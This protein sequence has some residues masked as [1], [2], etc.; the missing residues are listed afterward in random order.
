MGIL[1]K[2]KGLLP[3]SRV[4]YENSKITEI[5][6]SGITFEKLPK[7]FMAFPEV[8]KVTIESN[9]TTIPD[10]IQEM[11]DL[12]YLNI[13]LNNFSEIPKCL[14]NLENLKELVI[15]SNKPKS[16][17]PIE[18]NG[19]ENVSQI[20]KL[21]LDRTYL[22]KIPDSLKYLKDL[23]TLEMKNCGLRNIDNICSLVNLKEAYLNKNGIEK[24]PSCISQLKQLE[25]LEISIY[26]TQEAD[27]IFPNSF[28][29]LQKLKSLLFQRCYSKISQLPECLTNLNNLEIL[30]L[31]ETNFTLPDSISKL[32]KLKELIVTE[33]C[34][35]KKLPANIGWCE[36]LEKI[37]VRDTNIKDVSGSLT[38][39]QNL[40]YLDLSHNK[41]KRLPENLEKWKKLEYLDLTYNPIEYI[42]ES[43]GKLS[44]LKDL[45]IIDTPDGDFMIPKT[46]I[47]LKNL[48]STDL[49]RLRDSN[50]LWIREFVKTIISKQKE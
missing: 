36:N 9:L 50:E 1:V 2:I 40:R 42:P 37:T 45:Y 25:N 13:S 21:K 32:S 19:F 38:N 12:Q 26:N 33:N 7:I 3:K 11:S 48:E 14:R 30:H 20:T 4:F 16:E 22:E 35:I 31:Y 39:L 29:E 27:P 6:L 24:I 18:L 44:S 49:Y 5:D 41:I 46:I 8:K 43:I 34:T 17:T 28:G 10:E 23:E 15:Y 47:E